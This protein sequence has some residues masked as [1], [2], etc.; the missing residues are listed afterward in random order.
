VAAF[1]IDGYR[2]R[3]ELMYVMYSNVGHQVARFAMNNDRTM[4]LFTF[5]DDDASGPT[6]L[7]GQKAL[8]RKRFGRSG[9]ECPQILD[10][11]EAVT[12]LYFDRVSQIVMNHAAGSWTKGRVALVGDAASC[13]SLLGGQGSALA[14]TAAYVLAGELHN[15]N[16]DHLRAFARYQQFLG[17]FLADKQRAA[18]RFA[19]AFAP[20]SRLGLFLRNRLFQLLSLPWVASLTAGRGFKDNIAL[21]EY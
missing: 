6:D 21:P 14:M 17:S 3:D 4:F 8:L 2:P 11:L 7:A 5:A 10:A 19:T 20:N 12:D 13:V 9:W 15:A 16:G 1:Q 18:R